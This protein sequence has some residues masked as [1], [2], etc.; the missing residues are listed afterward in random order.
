M[1][2]ISKIPLEK[3]AQ[4]HECFK[5]DTYQACRSCGG[6]CEHNKIGTLLPGEKEFISKSL[7]IPI[8]TFENLY[9]DRLITSAG[10]VDVLKMVYDCPFLDKQNRCTIK[11]VKVVLCEIYPIVFSIDND[12]VKFHLDEKCQLTIDHEFSRLEEGAK[13]FE[14]LNVPLEWLRMVVAYDDLNFDYRQ[15]EKFRKNKN[16]YESFCL[17]EIM[18]FKIR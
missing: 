12:S 5:G 9:L 7:G 4:F 18:K 8:R 10:A 11:N 15:I 1:Y 2:L 13:C 17:S 6:K 14:A 3:F 16:V